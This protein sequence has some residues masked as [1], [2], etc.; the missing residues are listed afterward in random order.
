MGYQT[1]GLGRLS[2]ATTVVL[3][4]GLLAGCGGDSDGDSTETV[5]PVAFKACMLDGS[6]NRGIYDEVTEPAT[7]IQVTADAVEAEFFE[8]SKAD[9][10]LAFF[11]AF[12]GAD[13]A[14]EAAPVINTSISDLASALAE[15]S[16]KAAGDLGMS[17]VQVNDAIVIGTLP[18]EA[19]KQDEIEQET[20]ADVSGCLEEI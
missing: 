9:D 5:D 7:V 17:N 16:P 11:Y 19:D 15:G 2:L 18:F 6:I 13:A 4:F 3:T 1:M 14:Q 10:G 8:A 12:D 20:L